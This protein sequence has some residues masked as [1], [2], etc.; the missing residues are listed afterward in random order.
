M[1]LEVLLLLLLMVVVILVVVVLVMMIVVVVLVR[2]VIVVVVVV[3]IGADVL[4]ISL[5]YMV[6]GGIRNGDAGSGADIFGIYFCECCGVAVDAS[7]VGSVAV[8]IGLGCSIL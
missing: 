4:V 1:I 7:S 5:M 3:C 2:V 8:C 6:G